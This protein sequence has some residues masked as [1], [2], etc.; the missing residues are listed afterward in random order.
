MTF[1]G[2]GRGGMPEEPAG[3]RAAPGRPERGRTRAGL[4][5]VLGLA[6][7]C[8]C[9]AIEGAPRIRAG[10]IVFNTS[11]SAQ[12]RAIQLATRSPYS[13]MGLVLIREGRPFVLEA[14]A[15]VRL[16][17]LAEWARRGAGGRY[18]VRRLKDTRP[19][20]RPGGLE[21]L[22]RAALQFRGRP[23]DP[24]FEWSDERIYCS[25][26]VWKAFAR[27][28]GLR[29]GEPAALATFD[30]SSEMVQMK[31]R[32]R[33]GSEVPL[34]EPVISPAAMFE[35]PLLEGPGQAVEDR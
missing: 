17:P 19:L 26:L 28:L 25:E 1:P 24:Y 23:Y 33:Y 16:T 31:I 32:E 27:G 13:H 6:I 11:E 29:I 20:D 4:W 9:C 30:L 12:S 8:S 18:E 2:R 5:I 3:A 35:S 14:V 22:E 7:A 10:D 21:R 15:D 34:Q